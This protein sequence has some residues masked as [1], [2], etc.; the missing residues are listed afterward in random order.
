MKYLS[1]IFF[2]EKKLDALSKQEYEAWSTKA[3]PMMPS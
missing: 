3:W 2:D 1:M